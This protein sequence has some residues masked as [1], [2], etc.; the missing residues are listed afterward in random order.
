VRLRIEPV[1]ATLRTP[2][3]S[4]SGSIG[5]RQLLLVELRGRD[6]SVGYGEAA[7]LEHYDGVSIDD[8]R[9]ALEDCRE[10]LADLGDDAERTE[11]LSACARAAV[12]PQAVAAIDLALLDLWGRRAG[13]P[14]W[15][16]LGAASAPAVEVN[17]TIAAS[18]RAGAAAAA[19]LAREAGFR[20]IKVKV[21]IGDDAGRLAA[22]RAAAG[23]AMAI[24]IDAN[25][26]WSTEEA[27]ASLRVLEPIGIELCEEPASGLDAI[28]QIADA[29][30]V[31][32]ALDES[33][34]LPGALDDR[35]ADAVCLKISSSAG[36]TGVIEAAARARAAGYD[37]YLA[38]T[39]D[40][41]IG[42]AAALHAAAIV[43][44]DMPCGL[45]TLGLFD[46]RAD[47]LPPSGGRISPPDGAG[48]GTHLS[49][50]YR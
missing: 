46:G 41:P 12:L 10:L 2:F 6:G 11:V 39:L 47:P 31:P 27:V 4:A 14:V 1:E 42:I 13:L 45:A 32:V 50:W 19:A 3:V 44:P 21:G 29:S 18:D 25:G 20:S 16:L 28:A 30:P 48:L 15:R 9:T 26:A 37:V 40:G 36:V 33:A 17:A 5:A 49:D 34:R 38:S 7:P 43:R 23:P 24:R 22:V 35:F 8:C